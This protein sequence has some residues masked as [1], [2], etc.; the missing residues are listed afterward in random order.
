MASAT[1]IQDARAETA[2]ATASGTA[3][4]R[5]GHSY[6]FVVVIALEIAA[7][8]SVVRLA[9]TIVIYFS[10]FEHVVASATIGFVFAQCFLL[11]LW[12]ALGGLGTVPR[13]LIAGLVSTLGG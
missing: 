9:E 1:L 3:W 8:W 5:R 7:T 11:G 10:G 13:W 2:P 4:W 12:A 6:A